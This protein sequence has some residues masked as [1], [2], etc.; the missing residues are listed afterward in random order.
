MKKPGD[1]ASRRA[2]NFV[3]QVFNLPCNGHQI[4]FGIRME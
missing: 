3:G 1:W 4:F 2:T